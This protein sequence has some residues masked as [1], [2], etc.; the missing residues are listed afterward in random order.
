MKWIEKFDLFLLDFDG[1][2]VDTEKLHYQ[3]YQRACARYGC[4]LVWDLSEHLSYAHKSSAVLREALYRAFPQLLQVDWDTFYQEKKKAYLELLRCEPPR[5]L[6]GVERFLNALSLARK[7]RCVV[8][9]SPREQV[10]LIQHTLPLLKTIPLWVTRE[11]YEAPKPAPDGYLKAIDLLADPGDRIIGFEDSL[12]GFS[13]LQ[14]TRALPVLICE[15]AHPQLQNL[16]ASRI[17]H[18]TS[19]SKIHPHSL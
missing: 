18:Y 4:N 16:D 11:D 5:L 3:A 10:E 6:T 17:H 9:H 13:A 14:Q 15:Q 1:L 12:R 2:L 7:K 8:T 19:F